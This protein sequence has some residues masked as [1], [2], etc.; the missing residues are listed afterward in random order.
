MN[1]CNVLRPSFLIYLREKSPV[2]TI[3]C[4]MYR[5]PRTLQV[6]G[7]YKNTSFSYLVVVF[8]FHFSVCKKFDYI[9]IDVWDLESTDG[10]DC[11]LPSSDPN[12]NTC[13]IAA[14]TSFFDSQRDE[15]NE[16]E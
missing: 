4:E 8:S 1:T 2:V 5:H 12:R 3:R 15:T 14:D 11:T 6:N 9:L 16:G 10:K 7:A 13:Q